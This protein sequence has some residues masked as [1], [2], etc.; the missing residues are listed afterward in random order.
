MSINVHIYPSQMTNESRILKIVKSIE[1]MDLF[2]R[3]YLLGINQSSK[4]QTEELVS[5]KIAIFR[6][7]INS[8]KWE[9]TKF[10]GKK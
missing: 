2:S 4:L 10:V 6:I 3:I 8:A 7:N 9:K 1:K 5:E